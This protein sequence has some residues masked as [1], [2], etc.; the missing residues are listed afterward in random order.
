MRSESAGML[1][2]ERRRTRALGGQRGGAGYQTRSAT[3]GRKPATRIAA[4]LVDAGADRG[5]PTGKQLNGEAQS[6]EKSEGEAKMQAKSEGRSE[7]IFKKQS[8]S[9]LVSCRQLIVLV[10]TGIPVSHCAHETSARSDAVI[11][12]AGAV[13][14]Q[15][16]GRHEVCV[17]SW[18]PSAALLAETVRRRLGPLDFYTPGSL[19]AQGPRR[20]RKTCV[21]V[22]CTL[23]G[24]GAWSQLPG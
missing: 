11:P 17:P 12:W 20:G 3:E 2:L 15:G 5:Q 22:G 10:R 16:R 14:V 8:P 19:D 13:Q 4:R 1:M 7:R 24:G 6:K 9:L 21:C 18:P 23:W